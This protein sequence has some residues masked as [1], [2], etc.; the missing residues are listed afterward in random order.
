MSKFYSN[1]V[2]IKGDIKIQRPEGLKKFTS[3]TKL[4]AFGIL[5]LFIFPAFMWSYTIA[6]DFYQNYKEAAERQAQYEKNRET[7]QPIIAGILA[8]A[9]AAIARLEASSEPLVKEKAKLFRDTHTFLKTVGFSDLSGQFANLKAESDALTRA[10]DTTYAGITTFKKTQVLINYLRRVD[11]ETKL[12]FNATKSAN[13]NARVREKWRE[14]Y[15][16][17]TFEEWSTFDEGRQN[18]VIHNVTKMIKDQENALDYT[19]AFYKRYAKADW[20]L[21][22][23]FD[24]KSA[25]NEAAGEEIRSK[26]EV[27]AP[28]GEKV[29]AS[30]KTVEDVKE[31]RAVALKEKYVTGTRPEDSV[32]A[33]Q[34]RIR[35]LREEQQAREQEAAERAARLKAEQEAREAEARRQ[36]EIEAEQRRQADAERKA[37]EA[38]ER[39]RR[40][41]EAKR[42]AKQKEQEAE[43]IVND[44]F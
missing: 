37:K 36:A 13:K 28:T 20:D 22:V 42:R 32:K 2:S 23:L 9:H 21:S 41:A 43:A 24:D 44:F 30:E 29:S 12:I 14:D 26:L 17:F 15:P 34:D 18:L 16:E 3:N 31:D 8:P 25:A 40:E 35:Q 4:I 7:K 11:E 39:E 19:A 33:E 6:S 1:K 38:V 10:A 5:A 27:P